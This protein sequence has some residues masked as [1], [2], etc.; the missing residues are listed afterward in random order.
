MPIKKKGHTYNFFIPTICETTK[1]I[2]PFNYLDPGNL[3]SYFAAKK[4]Y[5]GKQIISF[6]TLR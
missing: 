1:K 4:Q 2:P 5:A 3:D 6:R